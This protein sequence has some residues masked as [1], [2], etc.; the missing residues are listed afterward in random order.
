M[1]LPTM[2]IVYSS[3]FNLQTY[4][5]ISHLNNALNLSDSKYL[6]IVYSITVSQRIRKFLIM[7]IGLKELTA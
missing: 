5:L 6:V 2:A 4:Y 7:A 3:N 1:A